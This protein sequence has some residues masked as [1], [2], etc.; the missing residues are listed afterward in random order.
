MEPG[1]AVGGAE[2][3]TSSPLKRLVT[4]DE[5]LATAA[6]AESA[7]AAETTAAAAIIA[8]P[9]QRSITPFRCNSRFLDQITDQ[10]RDA[11]RNGAR[12]YR[13]KTPL[14]APS[15]DNITAE[16]PVRKTPLKTPSGDDIV[17][18]NLDNN[19]LETPRRKT[20]LRA[21]SGDGL[22]QMHSGGLMAPS[23]ENC[24]VETPRRKT[25]L[26]AP[27]GDDFGTELLETPR[28][29]IDTSS[30]LKRMVKSA[31]NTTYSAD[32]S[33]VAATSPTKRPITPY[34][35][36][37]ESTQDQDKSLSRS[38]HSRHRST[39]P[40]RPK[41]DKGD[42]ESTHTSSS[43]RRSEAST[44]HRS[45]TPFRGATSQT[46]APESAHSAT[47]TYSIDTNSTLERMTKSPDSD[48][49]PPETPRR[50]STNVSR[51]VFYGSSGGAT[52]GRSGRVKSERLTQTDDAVH[53]M[54]KPERL[55]R[56]VS[57][58]GEGVSRHRN[59][60]DDA[61]A[62]SRHSVKSTTSPFEKEAAPPSMLSRARSKSTSKRVSSNKLA[63]SSFLNEE[64]ARSKSTGRAAPSTSSS[65]V[66]LFAPSKH[67]TK[68]RTR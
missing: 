13:P 52:P 21:P 10:E 31:D 3:D 32:S 56:S 37:V 48:L 65:S 23:Q 38:S 62:R 9:V 55:T 42:S 58:D 20:P 34:R 68:Q 8:S 33:P 39:T 26:R 7:T 30:P 16:T 51:R 47:H 1:S 61:L 44:R 50:R 2:I 11:L 57:E 5:N 29:D 17:Q 27:S 53:S 54:S 15:G 63:A 36:K 6:A 19:I 67:D 12:P 40:Y 22:L 18:M 41:K 59:R 14:R 60:S 25:P 4:S 35:R 28:T 45:T 49:T 66:P 24:I 46:E 43:R 64:K